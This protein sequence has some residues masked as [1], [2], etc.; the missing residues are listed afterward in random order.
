MLGNSVMEEIAALT[1]NKNSPEED[2]SWLQE[3]EEYVRVLIEECRKMLLSE[4][5]Q[6]MGGWALIDC[7]T[8]SV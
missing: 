7:A 4:Q 1:S 5:E 6:Y 8:R 2:S 3:K